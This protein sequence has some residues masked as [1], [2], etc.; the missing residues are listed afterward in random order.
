M[1]AHVCDR[2][3]VCQR[4]RAT[5]ETKPCMKL[6]AEAIGLVWISLSD[7]QVGGLMPSESWLVCPPG[8]AP[9]Y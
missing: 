3:C 7:G 9:V 1:G 8:P 4:V 6:L 5:Q 2:V